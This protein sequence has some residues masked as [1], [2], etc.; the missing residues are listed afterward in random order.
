[1]VI[2]KIKTYKGCYGL[3][4]LLVMAC[5][6]KVDGQTA[7]EYYKKG[8]EKLASNHYK[9]A[10]KYFDSSILINSKF[11]SA[12][13]RRGTAKDQLGFYKAAIL[14]YD[15][16]IILNNS[17]DYFYQNRD[18]ICSSFILKRFIL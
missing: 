3:L 1:M 14:D 17:A 10:I 9:D 15:T 16:A 2:N 7:E 8:K 12:Y 13:F 5:T 18:H 4:M 6:V 11:D